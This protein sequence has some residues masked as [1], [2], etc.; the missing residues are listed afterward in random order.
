MIALPVTACRPQPKTPLVVFAAGSLIRPFGELEKA[1]EASHP[2]IDVLSEY[3]G[4]IQVMRHVTDLHEPIDLVATADQSLIPMVM[5]AAKN[6]DSGR[7]YADWYVRFAG[8]R[9]ALAY[10]P[11]SKYA[12]EITP[13][14]WAEI[15]SRPDVRFGLPDPRFDASGYRALMILKLAEGVYGRPDLFE[16][17]LASGFRAPVKVSEIGDMSII[18]VPELLETREGGRLVLRGS[19]IALI[20][21]LQS[22][23][24][25]YAFEYESVIR[26]QGLKMVSLPASLN[27]GDESQAKAYGN[28]MVKLDFRRFAAVKPEFWGEP[29]GYGIT[30]P[31]SAAHPDEAAEY[32][33]FIL[34][35]EGRKIMADNAHPLLDPPRADG[36][37]R[38]PESLRTLCVAGP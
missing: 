13:E 16:E 32:L 14:N 25:D 1:F 6:P 21:L 33:A 30:I 20:A 31:S 19:S 34:G 18:Q 4:S 9:M 26:Q 11:R 7:P 12:Q 24:V 5:Y 29:I 35:P 28:V 2:Q 23:D 17:L 27:L 22:N 36:Y 15:I 38:M 37:E 8:N 10:T 3:H